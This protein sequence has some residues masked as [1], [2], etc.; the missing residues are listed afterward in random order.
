MRAVPNFFGLIP[1]YGHRVKWLLFFVA[2]I[3][4]PFCALPLCN[5]GTT[6][7]LRP[8]LPNTLSSPSLK[9]FSRFLQGVSIACYAEP[10]IGYGRDV[11]LSVSPSV[12]PSHAGTE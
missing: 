4:L 8:I 2:Y 9:Q 5:R 3:L 7:A 10:C 1:N 6:I 11:C 12:C